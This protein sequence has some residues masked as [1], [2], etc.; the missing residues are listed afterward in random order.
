MF[1]STQQRHVLIGSE[2]TQWLVGH[3][4]GDTELFVTF[5]WKPIVLDNVGVALRYS[6]L[7]NGETFCLREFRRIRIRSVSL[8]CSS[9][10]LQ[11][12]N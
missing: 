7:L 1:D 12:S 8:G 10:T 2:V 5:D 4:D 6:G 3:R 11:R 9:T